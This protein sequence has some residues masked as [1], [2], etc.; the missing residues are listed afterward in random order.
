M[1]MIDASCINVPILIEAMLNIENV[2]GNWWR[3]DCEF[4]TKERGGRSI[5]AIRHAPTGRYLRHS[6]GPVQG[7]SW[8]M[9][10]DDYMRPEWALIA[11]S[12]APAPDMIRP[13]S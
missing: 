11:L 6:K 8:D 12:M 7:H 3:R 9:Y 13:R 2:P 10:G 1:R 4:V 5:L